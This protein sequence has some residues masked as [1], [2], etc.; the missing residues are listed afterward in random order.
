[1]TACLVLLPLLAHAQD[2][3]WSVTRHHP[4]GGN[5]RPH[6]PTGTSTTPHPHTPPTTGPQTFQP[7][8]PEAGRSRRDRMIASLT[9]SILR[10]ASDDAAPMTV[11]L[12]LVRERDGNIDGL[13]RDF[14][15]RAAA[16]GPTD[17]A[18]HLV[19]GHVYAESGRFEDALR[20]YAVAERAA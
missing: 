3:D 19:L 5:H 13:V 2:D 9:Q 6:T 7:Q 16:A 20:E 12:R 18:P 17:A 14:E 15:Q 10:D 11:L 8:S 1:M 4:T